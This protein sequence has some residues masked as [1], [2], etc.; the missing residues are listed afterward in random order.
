MKEWVVPLDYDG[1]RLD[2]FLKQ[3][4]PAVPHSF[5]ARLARTGKLRVDK[6]RTS[7]NA[8]LKDGQHVTLYALFSEN[9]EKS[10]STR[11]SSRPLSSKDL[12]TFHRWIIYENDHFLAINKPMHVATQG[13]AKVTHHV[14][15]YLH[16]LNYVHQRSWK[17]VHRLDKDTSGVLLIAKNIQAARILTKAFKDAAIEKTYWA[18]TMGVPTPLIGEIKA[19]LLKKMIGG[20]E[21]VVEDPQGDRAFTSYRVLDVAGRK[22]ALVE[23]MP[24]TGRTHQL[25]A[26]MLILGTPILGD[27]KYKNDRVPIENIPSTLHLHA[28]SLKMPDLFGG[29][30]VTIEARPGESFLKSCALLGFQV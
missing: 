24:R 28:A 5:L 1:Q 18:L 12:Q 27:P 29:G 23:L 14:D 22:A 26:H 8:R 21:L 4:L 16:H 2:R 9:K 19:P 25:R 3:Q 17:L 6:K 10:L 13:G 30:P 20:Q 7:L 15:A 11:S